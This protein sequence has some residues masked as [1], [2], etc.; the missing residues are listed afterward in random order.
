MI[1]KTAYLYFHQGWTD[2]INQMCLI[3][4]YSN[5]YEKV[6]LINRKDSSDLINFYIRNISNI[7]VIY[8]TFTSNYFLFDYQNNDIIQRIF[9]DKNCDIVFHGLHDKIRNDEY[10]NIFLDK[11]PD[12]FFVKK[13]FVNYDFDYMDR[14]NKFNLDRDFDLENEK[15]EMF[16]NKKCEKYILYHEDKNRNIIINNNKTDNMYD[17]NNSTSIFFDYIKILENAK[18]IHLI[19]SVWASLIYLIDAKYRLFENIPI[20]IYC[21][22]GYEEMFTEPIKMNNWEIKNK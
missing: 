6:V 12:M 11:N 14:I 18:E 13:F 2:I 8:R 1:N 19:D 16:I 3:N 21:L 5:L 20:Y 7:E 15:Y 9:N 22:R 10:K 4:H 17:L